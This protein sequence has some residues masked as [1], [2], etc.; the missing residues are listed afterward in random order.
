[1][2]GV[3]GQRSR[4]TCPS[5]IRV[6]GC[7]DEDGT[8]TLASGCYVFGTSDDARDGKLHVNTPKGEIT[9]NFLSRPSSP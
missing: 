3:V 4:T 9:E 1:M 8:L 2:A 5:L 7:A 6:L